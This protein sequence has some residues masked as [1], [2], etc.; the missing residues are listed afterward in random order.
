ML[1][2]IIKAIRDREYISFTYSGLH[3]VAQ[4]AAAGVSRAGNDVL[5]CYQTEGG[6]ITPGH[7]WDFC[8]ISK[9]SNLATTGK[10]FEVNPPGYKK[11]DS[12]MIS[13]YAEL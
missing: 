5:R 7:E 4:P 13:I 9:I 10:Y 2:T 1:Q 8:E 3:R 11:G 12:H 6:H